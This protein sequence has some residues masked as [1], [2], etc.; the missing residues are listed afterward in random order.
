MIF[1]ASASIFSRFSSVRSTT[2]S[3]SN[4]TL[5]SVPSSISCFSAAEIILTVFNNSCFE[6]LKVASFIGAWG[7]TSAYFSIL[8]LSSPAPIT[9][10]ITTFFCPQ[11][12][13]QEVS[14]F[15]SPSAVASLITVHS[16]DQSC[17]GAAIVTASFVVAVFPS[18]SSNSFLHRS[19]KH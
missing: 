1:R 2:L 15:P 18:A 4:Q 9:G 17:P 10:R 6:L 12:L 7:A 14:F 19:D 8:L 13:T 5:A 3:I 11:P 16:P